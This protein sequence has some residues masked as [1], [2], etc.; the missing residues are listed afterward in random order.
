MK[1][2]TKTYLENDDINIDDKEQA[3]ERNA[4]KMFQNLKNN[5][6]GIITCYYYRYGLRQELTGELR[7]VNYFR[8]IK[9]SDTI[10]SFVGS[11]SAIHSITLEETGEVLY[12]NP[13][14]E[15]E[16]DK[17]KP[18]DVVLARKEIFDNDVVDKQE[19]RRKKYEE[20]WREFSEALTLQNPKIKEKL[21]KQGL[22]LIRPETLE[23]WIWFVKKHTNDV[24]SSHILKATISMMQKIEEGVPFKD[25]EKQVYDEEFIL[26]GFQE[27]RTARALS[28]FSKQGVEYREHRNKKYGV[29]DDAKGTVNSVVLTLKPK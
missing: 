14:I 29:N 15:L 23:Q 12:L 2:T 9:I 4:I 21:I 26:S 11:I 17:T 8:D 27:E 25:A 16:Y 10:I 1:T 13:F 24:Y 28:F 20:S 7:S 22:P 6:G 19:A 3:K 5:I 18:Q